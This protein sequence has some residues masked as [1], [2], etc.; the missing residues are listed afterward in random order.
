MFLLGTIR[1]WV[2]NLHLELLED[3]DISGGDGVRRVSEN[4]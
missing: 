3:F 2:E 4:A 1:K